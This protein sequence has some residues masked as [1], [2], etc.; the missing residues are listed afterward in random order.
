MTHRL[1]L[2]PVV[3]VALLLSTAATCPPSTADPQARAAFYANEAVIR[4]GEIQNTA[5]QANSTGGLSDHDAVIA[6]RFTV[7][8]TKIVKD[9]PSGWQLPVT[10]ALA[11]VRTALHPAAGT[12]LDVAF[13]ILQ[14]LLTKIQTGAP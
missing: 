8:A 13:T 14:A 12:P 7:S 10:T 5:I 1:R 9:A 3:L 4:L 6:V 2:S 11:E